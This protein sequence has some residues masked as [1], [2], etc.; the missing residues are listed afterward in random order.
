MASSKVVRVKC[1]EFFSESDEELFFIGLRLA[2]SVRSY[3]GVGHELVLRV[4]AG[5]DVALTA[6][7]KRYGV[8]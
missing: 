4:S 1:P 6:L 5:A 3:E 2:P 7:L 8:R